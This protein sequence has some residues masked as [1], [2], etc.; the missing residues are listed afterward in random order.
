MVAGWN[1]TLSGA[2]SD[3]DEVYMILRAMT[4]AAERSIGGS[5]CCEYSYITPSFIGRSPVGRRALHSSTP[6]RQLACQP[7]PSSTDPQYI[8]ESTCETATADSV[9]FSLASGIAYV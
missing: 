8:F 9:Q 7:S 3:Y 5:Q 4:H 2:A 1:K 6:A